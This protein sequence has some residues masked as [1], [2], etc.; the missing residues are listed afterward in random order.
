MENAVR[1][2]RVFS[3]IASLDVQEANAAIHSRYRRQQ[4]SVTS[5]CA[6]QKITKLFLT[7]LISLHSFCDSI[8]AMAWC[9]K[10]FAVHLFCSLHF[11]SNVEHINIYR[12]EMF[13]S[14]NFWRYSD[15]TQ[16]SSSS[17]LPYHCGHSMSRSAGGGSANGKTTTNFWQQTLEC[18]HT[19]TTTT[20][21][22]RDG[23][24]WHQNH[25]GTVF[26]EGFPW[27]TVFACFACYLLCCISRAQ[28]QRRPIHI[29]CIYRRTLLCVV[30]AFMWSFACEQP[31]SHQTDRNECGYT[32]ARTCM[33]HLMLTLRVW[34]V[35]CAA[36]CKYNSIVAVAASDIAL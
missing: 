23:C 13:A 5:H 9:N 6:K 8:Y 3:P 19:R 28:S 17:T 33:W 14:M 7:S 18:K 4:A 16:H 20:M 24:R 36:F 31:S 30:C 15:D 29:L 21:V 2:A 32:S 12:N 34:N 26:Y 22:N 27:R 10:P 35:M 25:F 11:G 1:V